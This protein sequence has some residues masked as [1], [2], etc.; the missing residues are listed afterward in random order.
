MQQQDLL[1][2][3]KGRRITEKLRVLRQFVSKKSASRAKKK[4]RKTSKNRIKH[5]PWR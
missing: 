4:Q 2:K 5:H 1:N 3:K